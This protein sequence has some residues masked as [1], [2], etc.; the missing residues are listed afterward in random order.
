MSG[1]PFRLHPLSLVSGSLV[2]GSPPGGG[3]STFG[4][5]ASAVFATDIPVGLSAALNEAYAADAVAEADADFE[6]A[7]AVEET[8]S[9]DV[10]DEPRIF[11]DEITCDAF[12]VKTK[13]GEFPSYG[14]AMRDDPKA[15][16]DACEKEIATLRS[17]NAFEEVPE[18]SLPG[19]HSKWKRSWT[20]SGELGQAE[21]CIDC[22]WALR[23]KTGP[24]GEVICL[25]A[26]CA[27]N[28]AMRQR[29][30]KAT[31]ARTGS[32]SS[33]ETFSPATCQATRSC[34]YAK[35]TADGK[36]CFCFDVTGAYL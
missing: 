15:L 31:A 30:M 22:L 26:R 34:L 1:S 4:G 21:E 10:R 20:K 19:W 8:E 23:Y 28:G 2:S 18:D 14:Q 36:A 13:G 29:K 35:G 33:V 27:F 12:A 24:D 7:F 5:N 9:R 3:D 11:F 16:E 6:T 17:F 32:V 25:K